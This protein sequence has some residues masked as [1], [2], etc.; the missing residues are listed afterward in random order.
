MH[1]ARHLESIRPR[2]KRKK[3]KIEENTGYEEDRLHSSFIT[4]RMKKIK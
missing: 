4:K 1:Y 2:M 3:E